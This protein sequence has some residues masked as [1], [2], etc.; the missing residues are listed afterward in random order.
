MLMRFEGHFFMSS[1]LK[2]LPAQSLSEQLSLEHVTLSFTDPSSGE[3]MI[4][5]PE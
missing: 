1:G 5:S 4:Q 2:S 3:R